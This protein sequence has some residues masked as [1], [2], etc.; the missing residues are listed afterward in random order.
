MRKG[1]RVQ[2]ALSI[3]GI[4]ALLAPGCQMN[5]QT[6]V[7]GANCIATQAELIRQAGVRLGLPVRTERMA[8]YAQSGATW[9]AA[10]AVNLETIPATELAH[11]VNAG[12][13]YFDLPGQKFPKGFY[14]MRA[15]ATVTQVGRFE[16]KG[17]LVNEKG[18]IVA[19]LPA[20]VEVRSMSLPGPTPS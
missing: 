17:Q 13:A 18:E 4:L 19:E 14:K 8:H 20:T 11:G 12:I 7:S 15:F 10:A 3:S 2:A 5:R 16:G 9:Y 6:E 1:M